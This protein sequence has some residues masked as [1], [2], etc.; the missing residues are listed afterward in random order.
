MQQ[1]EK[2]LVIV[3]N[4][5]PIVLEKQQDS[6][7]VSHGAGGLVTALAPVLR[8]RGG[9]WIGWPGT[10]DDGTL[11]EPI[12]QA[13]N[14]TGYRLVPVMLT[15]HD[16]DTYYH[17]FANEV[18][19]PLF[20]DLPSRCNFENEYWESYKEVNRKFAE[21]ILETT[22]QDDYIWVHDYHLMGVA[23]ELKKQ[24]PD[25]KAGFFLHIPFPSPD[26]FLKLPWRFELISALL[27]F[28]LIGF[29]TNRD[30]RN[31]AQC[32]R[33]LIKGARLYGKGAVVTVK[34]PERQVKIGSFPISIDYRQFV[35]QADTREVADCAWYFHENIGDRQIILGVDRLD[36]TKGIP[37]RLRAFERALE[38]Y[39]DMAGK[40]TFIQIVVPSRVTIPEYQH[41]RTEIEQVVSNINGR[42]TN[43]GWV[44]VQYIFRSIDRYQLLAHYRCADIALV[45]PLK[46][47]MNLVAKEY[48]ACSLEK[49]GVLILSEFAGASAQLHNS[50]LIVN[51]YD[52]ENVADAMYAA[53]QMGGDERKNRMHKLRT[54]IK[55]YD[56]FWWVDTFI[57]AAFTKHLENFPIIEDFDYIAQIVRQ[58][59]KHGAP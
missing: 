49:N 45:T 56:I 53:F 59:T 29:Q 12:T 34:L 16:I 19:W 3:S 48:C 14:E 22:N 40:V 17:G 47:G 33:A 21:V 7:H 54:S 39:P 46:D 24:Q 23:Q 58:R 44:P 57:Q 55:K 41:L 13:S 42:F 18:I 2:R 37:Q 35:Q 43:Y 51:P 30:R 50:A 36:Y 32:I 31:F 25:L 28:D 1:P 10:P 26:I 27:E 4:R 38:K 8:N 6:W 5:L 52:G 9:L 15:A 11:A 20:H